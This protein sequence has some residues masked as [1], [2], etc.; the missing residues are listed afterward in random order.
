MKFIAIIFTLISH[1]ASGELRGSTSEIQ[2]EA[3]ASV[4][5]TSRCPQGFIISQI[6]AN[7]GAILDRI[8][9]R[10]N[11]FPSLS[12]LGD[13]GCPLAHVSSPKS[14]TLK[15]IDPLKGWDFVNVGYSSYVP[16]N[17]GQELVVSIQFCQKDGSVCYETGF[18]KDLTICSADKTKSYACPKIMSYK[19]D[20]GKYMIG[21]SSQ[22]IPT[23][24]T[25]YV[26]KF[27]PLFA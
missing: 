2:I 6:N 3:V 1:F 14:V 25:G 27:E 8:N 24:N 21:A 20:T 17:E 18:F 19:A 13:W 11:N 23:W 12:S 5:K 16:Y 26:Q 22:Y 4:S 15:L 7:L 10:C 9:L